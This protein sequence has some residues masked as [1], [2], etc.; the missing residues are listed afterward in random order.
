MMWCTEGATRDGTCR[1]VEDAGYRMDGGDFDRF[2]VGKRGEDGRQSSRE[3]RLA[4]TWRTN[5]Y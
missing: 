1:G 3:H 4:G 5:E 2:S